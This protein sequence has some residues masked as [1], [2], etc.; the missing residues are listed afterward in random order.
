MTRSSIRPLPR[1]ILRDPVHLPAFGFGLGLSRYAPGSAG[2]FA[3]V[4]L[5]L[6]LMGLPWWGYALVVA[7]LFAVGVYLCGES[8]K[9]LG[10]H[11]HPGIVFDEIVGY[12]LTMFP[13]LPGLLGE[14]TYAPQWFWMLMGFVI[15]RVLDIWKPGYIRRVDAQFSGGYGI[16]LDDVVAAVIAALM[17]VVIA[18]PTVLFS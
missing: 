9:R 12:L 18:L 16:M 17:L 4:L 11:D 13:M 10:A 8:A 1:V 6:L 2:T 7:A 3:G 5:Y 15:F 14:Q